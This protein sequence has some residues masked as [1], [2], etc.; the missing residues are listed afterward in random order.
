MISGAD[1][2][3]P[4]FRSINH[5]GATMVRPLL[6]AM[7]EIKDPK[8]AQNGMAVVLRLVV[9]RIVAGNL[10]T[11]SIERMFSQAAYKTMHTGSAT[12]SLGDLATIN[13][14][15]YLFRSQAATRSLNPNTLGFLRHS[16]HLP[17]DHSRPNCFFASSQTSVCP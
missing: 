7:S 12:D 11:G 14:P 1:E 6:L 8:E 10:G 2:W 16:G 13:P 9:R 17:I 4:V 5:L 15:Q 3:L